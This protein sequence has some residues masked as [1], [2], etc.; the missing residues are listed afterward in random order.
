MKP[1][2]VHASVGF[3]GTGVMGR[4]M[5]G[6]L[7]DAGHRLLVYNRSHAKAGDLL[8]RGAVWCDTPAAL[9]A[10]CDVV[11]T[12]VGFPADVAEVYLGGHGLVEQARPGTVLVDMTTSSPS[13]AVQIAAAAAARGVF[14]LDAP[15]TGGD[16]GAREATLTILAGGDPAAFE[17]VRPLLALMGRKIVHLG[18]AGAGQHAKLANQIA[19]AGTI[20]G[21]C[22]ALAYAQSMGLDTARLLEAIDS[23]AAGSWQLR[24][25]GAKM[26]AGDFTPGFFV[27]HFI[28]DMSLALDASRRAGIELPA[29]KLALERYA[30]LA[31]AGGSELGTQGLFREYDEKD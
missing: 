17:R 20:Q 21:V 14:A 16:K 25:V 26:L 31:A 29:L 15:V 5:A 4:S 9:A 27:K 2:P 30:E 3:I 13:Q 11:F 12:I 10:G 22:E 28:K 7:L 6:H 24:N 1:D 18:A 19:I 23:G 8:R